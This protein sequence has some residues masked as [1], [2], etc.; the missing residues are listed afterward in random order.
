MNIT[1]TAETAA[2]E[3]AYTR[4]WQFK[5]RPQEPINPV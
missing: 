5:I 1:T 4:A 2:M 3:A